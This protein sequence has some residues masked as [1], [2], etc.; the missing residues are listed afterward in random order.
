MFVNQELYVGVTM[1]NTSQ[2]TWSSTQAYF[3]AVKSDPSNLFLGATR[4]PLPDPNAVVPAGI[5]LVAALER[6]NEV[7]VRVGIE[8]GRLVK[9][10]GVNGHAVDDHRHLDAAGP[11]LFDPA[12][13]A[14][15]SLHQTVGPCHVEATDITGAKRFE[16]LCVDDF[17]ED[18]TFACTE[19]PADG[20]R[21]YTVCGKP[22]DGRGRYL[23]CVGAISIV[24]AAL[25]AWLLGRP[26][27]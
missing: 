6:A 26:T 20:S 22:F 2:L 17:D 25:Y 16:F 4:I 14:S 13:H 9:R 19:R 10:H 21:W 27:A 23:V 18:F 7:A 15:A 8:V 11:Q 24:G 3:L 5:G 12:A 1:R